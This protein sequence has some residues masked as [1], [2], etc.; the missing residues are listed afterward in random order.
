MLTVSKKLKIALKL[1][2]KPAYQIAW[3]AGVNPNVLS[4]LINEIERVQPGDQRIIAVG[5]ILGVPAEECFHE[6]SN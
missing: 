5:K 1:N 2:P 6:E 3:A 4:K